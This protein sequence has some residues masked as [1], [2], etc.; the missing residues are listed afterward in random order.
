MRVR[1]ERTATDA[2]TRVALGYLGVPGRVAPARCF[3][4][5]VLRAKD[6]VPEA[7]LL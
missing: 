5:S 3:A 1:S 7:S 4:Y 6:A 2:R